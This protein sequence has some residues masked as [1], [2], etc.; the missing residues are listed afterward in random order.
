M[1]L[2]WLVDCCDLC[3]QV[4]R[5]NVESRNVGCSAKLNDRTTE[6]ESRS[7]VSAKLEPHHSI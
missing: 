1:V 6:S 7:T 2:S 3:G 5:N 4:I